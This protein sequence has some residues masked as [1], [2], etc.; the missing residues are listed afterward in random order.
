MSPIKDIYEEEFLNHDMIIL[1]P[2]GA[3]LK[4]YEHSAY[5]LGLSIKTFKPTKR[6]FK[7]LGAEIVSVGFPKS[8]FEK[9]MSGRKFQM[10]ERKFL[11]M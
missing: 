5:L 4:A 2:E 1:R 8:S 6:L 3:F 10:T 9:Y 7:K 11:W